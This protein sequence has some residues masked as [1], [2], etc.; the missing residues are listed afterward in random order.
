MK[1][2]KDLRH[3][4]IYDRIMGQCG[5]VVCSTKNYR[6]EEAKKAHAELRELFAKA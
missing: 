4:R 3:K 5:F 2:P 6:D 1:N